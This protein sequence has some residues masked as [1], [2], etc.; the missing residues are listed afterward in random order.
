VPP[1]TEPN[2][3]S[4]L[5]AGYARINTTTVSQPMIN[6]ND[7]RI[8]DRL[9]ILPTTG[10][11]ADIQLVTNGQTTGFRVSKSSTTPLVLTHVRIGDLFINGTA[12][13]GLDY[14]GSGPI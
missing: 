4:T 10:N 7:S 2:T 8:I 14:A 6:R 13:D 1:E 9:S 12:G 11:A 5:L 3:P